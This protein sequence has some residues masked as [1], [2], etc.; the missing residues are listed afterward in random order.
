M[1]KIRDDALSFVVVSLVGI[2]E[3]VVDMRV[4]YDNLRE[5]TEAF[6]ITCLHVTENGLDVQRVGCSRYFVRPPSP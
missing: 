4:L 1:Q 3:V 5:D 2:G 6:Q